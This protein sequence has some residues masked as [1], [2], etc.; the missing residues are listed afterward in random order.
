MDKISEELKAKVTVLLVGERSGLTTNERMSSYM[1]YEASTNCSF[2][3]NYDERKKEWY[4]IKNITS[5][6][7]KS[8]CK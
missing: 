4:R 6:S 5:K 1:A 2:D 8:L 3:I 7:Y